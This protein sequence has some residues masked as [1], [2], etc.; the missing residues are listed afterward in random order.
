MPIPAYLIYPDNVGEL[1]PLPGD[2][3]PAAVTLTMGRRVPESDDPDA[4]V[5]VSKVRAPCIG[6]RWVGAVNQFAFVY[7]GRS[8]E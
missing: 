5:P 4:V 7:D 2:R 1:Q 8:E 3:A 6:F